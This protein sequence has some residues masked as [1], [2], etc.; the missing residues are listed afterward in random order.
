MGRADPETAHWPDI[1][2]SGQ[3]NEYVHRNHAKVQFF[4]L[5]SRISVEHVGGHNPTLVNNRPVAEGES[6][7]LEPGDRLRV[8]RVLMRLVLID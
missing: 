3:D 7:E 4:D 6:V 5:A 2:L 8:G 1:D